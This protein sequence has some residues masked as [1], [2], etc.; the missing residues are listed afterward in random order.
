MK[1]PVS[2]SQ[3][4]NEICFNFKYV[5]YSRISRNIIFKLFKSIVKHFL[6]FLTAASSYEERWARVSGCINTCRLLLYLVRNVND[7]CRWQSLHWIYKWILAKTAGRIWAMT[8]GHKLGHSFCKSTGSESNDEI[9]AILQMVY[10]NI[11][12]KIVNYNKIFL[13]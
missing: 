2:D 1:G 12:W 6:F 7:R 9:K 5:Q 4:Q 8:I 11:M 10:E 3:Q 13:E